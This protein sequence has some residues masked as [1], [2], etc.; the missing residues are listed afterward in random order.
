MKILNKKRKRNPS[1]NKEIENLLVYKRGRKKLNDD[2]SRTHGKYSFDNI[3]KKI[4]LKLL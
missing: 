3:M 2:T 1:K 4:K